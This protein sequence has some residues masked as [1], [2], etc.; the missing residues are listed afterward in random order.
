MARPTEIS[1]YVTMKRR[2]RTNSFC[3]KAHHNKSKVSFGKV[4]REHL[5]K[6]QAKNGNRQIIP[7]HPS[8]Y[9]KLDLLG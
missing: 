3:S 1:M 6:A 5:E 7:R 8:E 4:C 9:Q 2:E